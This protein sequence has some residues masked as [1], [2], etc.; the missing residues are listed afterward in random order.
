[1]ER[2]R[3]IKEDRGS[4]A[5][6]TGGTGEG[7]GY[8]EGA[9]RYRGRRGGSITRDLPDSCRGRSTLAKFTSNESQFIRTQAQSSDE[10]FK[11]RRN[12]DD[13]GGTGASG[14]EHAA[15]SLMAGYGCYLCIDNGY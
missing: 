7:E 1:M 15:K 14:N 11:Y 2:R 12:D 9:T 5:A 13:R 10:E 3:S 8:S 4:R 6:P